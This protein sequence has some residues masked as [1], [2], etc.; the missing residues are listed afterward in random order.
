MRPV[1]ASGGMAA[2]TGAGWSTGRVSGPM[3]PLRHRVTDV[4]AELADTVTLTL[5]PL[6]APLA[7]FRAGQFNM[8]WGF[9]TGEVPIS[10][11]GDPT[12][13]DRLLH[14]IRAV[15]ASTQA[16][17]AL[18]PGAVVGVRGPFGSHW[19]VASAEGRD[20]VIVAGGIGLAPLRPLV[21]GIIARRRAFER[22]AL[23]VG[24]RSPQDMLFPDDLE[25]WRSF[26][27]DVHVTVDHAG[28]GWRG[29]V[30]VVT[31]LLPRAQV[32]PADTVAF[33]CGPE[34]MMRFA[35][36]GLIDLGV[37]DASIRVSLER[38]MKCAIA[39]CGHCQLGPTFVCR[40]G[41]VY[42]Y[43]VAGPLMT[44]RGL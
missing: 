18:D 30:G 9:G 17:C 38:N 7:P 37:D 22:V 1:E 42:S 15:G 39:H 4:R 32:D 6:E 27:I 8:L 2:R 10:L 35:A 44:I 23:L 11:S 29:D 34:V 5:E 20:V 41:P 3:I 31:R 13:G 14:T 36:A 33:V 21:L 16:L 25:R 19:D 43:E 28:A 26:D 12:Q 40:E 24:A